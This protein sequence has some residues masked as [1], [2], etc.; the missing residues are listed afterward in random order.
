M[1][2]VASNFSQIISINYFGYD[3]FESLTQETYE[4]EV[5]KKP[6]TR[7]EVDM[8]LR[9]TGASINL[10]AGDTH[11]TMQNSATL[12]KMDFV[13]IDGGHAEETVNNDWR[14]VEKV[15]NNKTVVIFD[16]YWHN[17]KD[18]PKVV[19]DNIDRNK[20][21]VEILPEVD[22]FFNPRMTAFTMSSGYA[23]FSDFPHCLLLLNIGQPVHRVF[24]GS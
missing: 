10:Y 24:H 8:Y 7:N 15:M 14:A 17:R 20:Y 9:Q 3:L 21:R 4:Y 2:E 6:P 23:S 13:F 22:V 19:I 5:S 16:D 1:I 18:G 12:P 11:Q